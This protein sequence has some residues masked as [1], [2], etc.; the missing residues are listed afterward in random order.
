MKTKNSIKYFTLFTIMVIGAS[1]FFSS[2]NKYEEGPSFSLVSAT[3]RITGTWKLTETIL[4]DSP[5]DLNEL[6]DL[7]GGNME[8]DTS[9]GFDIDLSTIDITSVKATFNKDGSGNFIFAVSYLGFPVS[10]TENTTWVFDDKKENID[11]TLMEEIQSF[12]ILRLT[13]DEL[14]LRRTETDDNS[15]NILVLKMEKED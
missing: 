6:I 11:I 2:C 7:L 12:E 9:S 1:V 3:K 13:K 8:Q 4:N 14:W 10:Q 15:T 5:V